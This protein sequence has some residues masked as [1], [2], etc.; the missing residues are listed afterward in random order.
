MQ[1]HLDS[2]TARPRTHVRRWRAF[3]LVELLLLLALIGILAAVAVPA[4]ASYRERVRIAQA[5]MDLRVLDT[6]IQNH[7][8]DRNAL[9]ED[10]ADIGWAGRLD[11]WGRPYQY[12]GFLTPGD[13]GRARKNRNLVPINTDFDLYSLGPDG[14]TAIPLTA[15]ASRDD[16][17]RA[18]DGRFVGV[19]AAYD[20]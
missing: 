13:A 18:N 1:T 16:I 14:V 9:P 3:T 2:G 19:A 10:L 11:P 17:V 6:T 4:Y 5:V 7:R 15:S 12:N 8:L 20:P